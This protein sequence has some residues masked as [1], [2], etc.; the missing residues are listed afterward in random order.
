M[1]SHPWSALLHVWLCWVTGPS[2]DLE[3][4][5][6]PHGL[7]CGWSVV[8]AETRAGMPRD[9]SQGERCG[10]PG[11]KLAVAQAGGAVPTEC[12]GQM[13]GGMGWLAS[14]GTGV[15]CGRATGVAVQCLAWGCGLDLSPGVGRRGG[16]P[17]DTCSLQ[18]EHE[19][20][21]RPL[22]G[23]WGRWLWA[24]RRTCAPALPASMSSQQSL[25]G[26]VLRLVGMVFSASVIQCPSQ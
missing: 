22:A 5:V 6:G 12:G 13:W 18:G 8:G 21:A 10:G 14:Y 3:T 25:T 2:F 9:V 17:R 23:H 11:R 26:C 16:R 19:T 20:P 24:W 7:V 4:G 15:G 1:A